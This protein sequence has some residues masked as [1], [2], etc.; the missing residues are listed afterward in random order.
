MPNSNKEFL[1][2]LK[3]E[4]K[5]ISSLK[6]EKFIPD[7]LSNIANFVATHAWQIL[8]FLALVS[9]FVWELFFYQGSN[10]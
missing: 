7:R 8:L 5:L 3:S 6:K 4:A 10:G 1:K 2:K 9:S